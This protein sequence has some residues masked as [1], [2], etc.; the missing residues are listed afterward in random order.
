MARGVQESLE[1]PDAVR[2]QGSVKKKKKKSTF[3]II[4]TW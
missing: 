3:G 2:G 1:F 4:W